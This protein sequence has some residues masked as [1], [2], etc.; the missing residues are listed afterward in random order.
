MKIVLVWREEACTP[1]G[2]YTFDPTNPFDGIEVLGIVETDEDAMSLI[3]S[4]QVDHP[5]WKFHIDEVR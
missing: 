5:D 3:D 1:T 2:V 4:F